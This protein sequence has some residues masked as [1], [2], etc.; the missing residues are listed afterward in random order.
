MNYK[1]LGKIYKIGKILNVSKRERIFCIFDK[2]CPWE[3]SVEYHS[4]HTE[5]DIV[6]IFGK[7]S[8][9]LSREYYKHSRIDV[10]RMNV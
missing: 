5:H 6:P 4:P 1:V 2:E 10:F 9:V 3:L 8:S 7:G